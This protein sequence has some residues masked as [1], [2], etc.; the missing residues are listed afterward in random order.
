M[1]AS[2]KKRFLDLLEK[3]SEF[4][5]T[6]IGYL[7]LSETLEKLNALAA[8]QSKIRKEMSKTW[9][10]IK[11]LREEQVKIWEEIK[12][13]REGQNKLWEEVRRLREEQA[14]IWEEIKQLRE[15]QSKLREEQVKI[16]EE[17]KQLREEQVKIR[18]EQAKIWEEI[19]QLREEQAKIWEEIKQLREEQVKIWEEIKQ[20]REGQNKLWEEVRD[21]RVTLNRVVITLDRLTLSVE[22][23][24]ASWIRHRL[25]EKLG[26]EIEIGRL[27]IDSKEVNFYGAVGD[28]CVVGEATV[29]LGVGLVE[30][31]KEK[32]K[33]IEEKRPELLRPK[34]VKVIYADYATPDALELARREK[35]WVL[36]WSGDLT[37]M[38]VEER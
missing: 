6:V 10:E 13:L 35:V 33:L 28:L 11:R 2:L 4:R 1:G 18:E 20:L 25:K 30:E 23:E 29:R 34:I 16:W 22:E 21:I 27:F 36:K 7:G 8:E 17:I 38:V 32:V 9:K 24:A 26:V 19:K 3:D 31:L 14:K 37:P 5:H 12:Q 15:E